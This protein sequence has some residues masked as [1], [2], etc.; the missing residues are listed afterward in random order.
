LAGVNAASPT[1]PPTAHMVAPDP[2]HSGQSRPPALPAPGLC[3]RHNRMAANRSRSPRMGGATGTTAWRQT[4]TRFVHRA[5]FARGVDTRQ[6]TRSPLS[7]LDWTLHHL[8]DTKISVKY[9]RRGEK[10]WNGGSWGAEVYKENHRS[11][12]KPP[13]TSTITRLT[14]PPATTTCGWKRYTK[15]PIQTARRFHRKANRSYSPPSWR[16]RDWRGAKQPRRRRGR[17][18]SGAPQSPVA[19]QRRCAQKRG[20][21]SSGGR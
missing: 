13:R 2:P 12:P 10:D 18:D 6:S 16:A 15:S 7:A 1:R 8:V 19:A 5:R 17:S 9:N 3:H 21:V 14:L 11:T 20:A 4:A